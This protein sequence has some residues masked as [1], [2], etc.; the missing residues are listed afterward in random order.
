MVI[1]VISNVP[2]KSISKYAPGSSFVDEYERTFS[3]IALVATAEG[4]FG[5]TED[6]ETVPFIALL[7]P[8][9]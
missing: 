4:S 5:S 8:P 7:I 2:L 1:L 9:E 6:C 3:S